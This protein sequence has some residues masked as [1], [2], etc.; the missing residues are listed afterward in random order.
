MKL[1]N[2][3][4]TATEEYIKISYF[5]KSI[6]WWSN[7]TSFIFFIRLQWKLT[8]G[9]TIIEDMKINLVGKYIK[10]SQ[11]S[12]KDINKLGPAK[13]FCK[14]SSILI[15]FTLTTRWVVMVWPM[16]KLYIFTATPPA[17]QSNLLG[18]WKPS[19]LMIYCI[20]SMGV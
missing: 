9:K 3:T 14:I 12:S 7:I 1:T 13:G 8:R 16:Y 11:V 2:Y 6:K 15:I 10:S 17:Y 18:F 4:L 19:G 20:K 5:T